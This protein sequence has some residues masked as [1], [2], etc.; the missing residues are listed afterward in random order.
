MDAHS[1]PGSQAR[2]T[3]DL[4]ALADNWRTLEGLAPGAATAAVVKADAYGI[5][6]EPA[7]R[8]LAAAG[9]R[10]FFVA[11][12]RSFAAFSG[13]AYRACAASSSACA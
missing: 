11:R 8:T 5:G 6:I 3:I 10:T 12:A 7:V 1:D 4:A 2:L 9:C 13:S